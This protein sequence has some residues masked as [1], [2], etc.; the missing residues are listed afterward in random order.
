[1]SAAGRARDILLAAAIHFVASLLIAVVAFGRDMDQLRTRTAW[2]RAA[3]EVHD[4]LWFPHDRALRAIPNAWLV[5]NQ[6][7]ISTALVV[8]SLLWGAAL[9]ALWRLLRRPRPRAPRGG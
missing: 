8:N 3:A 7:V 5:R 4:V 1:M 6:W 9:Y 2:S